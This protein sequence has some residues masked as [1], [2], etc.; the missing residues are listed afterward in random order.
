M[1]Y[2]TVHIG[3]APGISFQ[4]WYRSQYFFEFLAE[5]GGLYL[6]WLR[7]MTVLFVSYNAFIQQQSMLK[8]LYWLTDLSQVTK[9]PIKL[10]QDSDDEE[11]DKQDAIT[12]SKLFKTALE[13][14]SSITVNYFSYLFVYY[15]NNLCCC[16]ATCCQ[17]NSSSWTKRL[18]KYKKF[19]LAFERLKGEQDIQYL[20]Q[21]NRVTRLL[22]KARFMSRQ[23]LAVNY[24]HKFIIN[25]QDVEAK[26]K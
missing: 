23:R 20:I 24:S 18:K 7:V 11:A 13:G 6:S 4:T 22:H 5:L 3:Q 2:A 14:R 1:E 17:R 21:M 25:D 8:R 10:N 26:E 12:N 16:F 15:L 19:D 9:E